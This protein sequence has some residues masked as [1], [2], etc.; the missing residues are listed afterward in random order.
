MDSITQ[1]GDPE[2]ERKIAAVVATTTE[3]AKDGQRNRSELRRLFAEL[4]GLKACRS[5]S[6][7]H[8]LDCEIGLGE[9]A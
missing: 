5:L 7:I 8:K 1:L 6:V 4:G 3:M 9:L 2:L